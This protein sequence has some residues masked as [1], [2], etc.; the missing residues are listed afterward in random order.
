MTV[1]FTI[2]LLYKWE[3]KFFKIEDWGY[4]SLVLTF[5]YSYLFPENIRILLMLKIG[6]GIFHIVKVSWKK[7]PE[8][9]YFDDL[10]TCILSLIC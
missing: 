10:F 3:N 4:H 1:D 6:K 9:P 2:M 5:F 7:Y 8:E